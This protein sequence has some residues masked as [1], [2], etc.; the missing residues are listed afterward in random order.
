MVKNR[1]VAEQELLAE[2]KTLQAD[3]E[4][5]KETVCNLTDALNAANKTI[6][7]FRSVLEQIQKEN[8]EAEEEEEE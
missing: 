4:A 6:T 2:M 5:L 3:Y 8:P 1:S 7:A